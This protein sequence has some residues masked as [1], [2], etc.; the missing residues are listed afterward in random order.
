MEIFYRFLAVI[1]ALIFTAGLS[2]LLSWPVQLLWNNVAVY[3]IDG[4]HTLNFLSAWGLTVLASL[5]FKS[6]K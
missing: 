4:L 6:L 1:L 2:A 3:A 5:L